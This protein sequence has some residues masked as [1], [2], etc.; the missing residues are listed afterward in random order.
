MPGGGA[1]IVSSRVARR[2]SWILGGAAF[3]TVYVALL[4]YPAARIAHLLLPDAHLAAPLALVFCAPILI[5]IWVELAPSR[6]TRACSRYSLTFLGICFMAWTPVIGFEVVNT[7]TPLPSAMA[8]TTLLALVCIAALYAC[9]NALHIRVRAMDIRTGRP[10]AQTRTIAQ[11][12][13]LHIGSLHPRQLQGVVSRLRAA[14]PDY[15][16]LTGDIID[17]RDIPV[18]DL[19]PLASLDMP[20]LFIIG[21]HERYVDVDDIC[22]RLENL[23]VEVLRNASSVHGDIQFVG[24]DDAESKGQVAK[25][26]PQIAALPDRLRILLYHRPDGAED[27]AAWG[28]H[29]MLCG[30]THNGQIVPFNLLVRRFFPRIIGLH[31]VGDM[32]LYVSP[33]TGVWGPVLRLGSHSEITLL[34]VH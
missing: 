24:I 25:R 20:V 11:V 2:A 22:A 13:D 10:T 32:Q 28:A 1:G 4:V 17:F 14:S 5:R 6:L 34:R 18:A 9:W 23:G 33:G 7:I 27:A 30:H 15:V 21:N 8:G 16:V 3:F 29:L 12:S 31:R 26:L 19:A